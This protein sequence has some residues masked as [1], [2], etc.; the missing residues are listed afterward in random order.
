MEASSSTEWST[1]V[2]SFHTK[3][4]E[5]SPRAAQGWLC[6]KGNSDPTALLQLQR[7]ITTAA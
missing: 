2:S 7:W 4:R 3:P 5:A 6:C 1:L